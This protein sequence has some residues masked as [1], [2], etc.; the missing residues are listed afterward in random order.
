L[1]IKNLNNLIDVLVL[2]TNI[3]TQY[4][5]DEFVD[6]RIPDEKY[7]HDNGAIYHLATILSVNE[8]QVK[9]NFNRYNLLDNNVVFVKGFFEHSLVNLPTNKLAILRLDG[10]MYSSTM[11]VLE[12]LYDKVSTG[13]YIIIDDYVLP[14][15]YTAIHDFRIKRGINDEIITIDPYSAYWKKSS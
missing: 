4:N 5:G 1:D 7:P 6:I 2:D 10:D 12:Q 8:E 15:C 14:A 9:E 13:G 3:E 11:Q